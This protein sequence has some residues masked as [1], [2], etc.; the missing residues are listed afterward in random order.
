MKAVVKKSAGLDVHKKIIVGTILLEQ[1]DGSV[2]EETKEFGTTA[3]DCEALS[4]W[5]SAH[6]IDLTVM[7]STGIYWKN[8]YAALENKGLSVSV[9]NARHVKQVPGR[10][11]DVK[12]SQWLA[13]LARYGLLKGSFIPS[14]DLRE[15]R[16]VARYRTKLQRTLSSELN[17][18]HKILDDAGIRLGNVVSNINGMTA[19]DIINGLIK[20]ESIEKLLTYVR[21]KLKKK[22]EELRAELEGEIS[23][24]HLFLLK[25]IKDHVHHLSKEISELDEY[26]FSAMEPYQQQWEMLQTIPGISTITAALLIIEMG[27]DMQAFGNREQFCSWAGMCPGNNE[28]AGK[29]KSGKTRKGNNQL[30]YLLCESANAAA[31]THGQF[32]QKY[33]SL[34]VRRGHKK[35]VIAIGHKLLR[36]IFSV[37]KEKKYYQDPV[38]DYEQLVVHKNSAR[39]LKMLKKY[40]VITDK[41]ADVIIA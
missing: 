14:K 37:L 29:K 12:D 16:L 8:I 15:L 1:S 4:N 30:R 6:A 10:K 20:G 40:G 18:L 36:V 9:V 28:S 11:T 26:L 13:R 32:K 23:A 24:R 7:E 41:K 27:V 31:K 19:S 35:A 5:L 25:K 39:W 2:L 21:G 17:R 3:R 38:I 34:L 33:K 22:T